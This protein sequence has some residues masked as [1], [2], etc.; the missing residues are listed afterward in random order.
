MSERSADPLLPGTG[1]PAHPWSITRPRHRGAVR[2]TGTTG[3]TAVPA[4]EPD[5]VS[6]SLHCEGNRPEPSTTGTTVAGPRTG[7]CRP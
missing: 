3:G 7:R 5:T 2:I 6:G 4:F 1:R